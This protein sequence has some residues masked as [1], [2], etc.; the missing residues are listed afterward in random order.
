MLRYLQ[1]LHADEFLY[2]LYVWRVRYNTLNVADADILD[3][4]DIDIDN[5][6]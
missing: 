5:L 6:R 4:T 1:L 2:V 3:I